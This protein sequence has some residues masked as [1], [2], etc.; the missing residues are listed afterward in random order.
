MRDAVRER[1]RRVMLAE[2]TVDRNKGFL[3]TGRGYHQAGEKK[4]KTTQAKLSVRPSLATHRGPSQ[5]RVL[6]L[7]RPGQGMQG[8][9]ATVSRPNGLQPAGS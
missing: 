3:R 9:P 2:G 7:A 6:A 5:A 4:K 1:A 8:Q